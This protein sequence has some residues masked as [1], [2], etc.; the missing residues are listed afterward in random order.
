MSDGREWP[1][2]QRRDRGARGRHA[3]QR[4]VPAD[5]PR[6]DHWHQAEDPDPYNRAE[7]HYQ[8][9]PLPTGP[10]SGPFPAGPPSGPFPAPPS[11]RSPRHHPL[12]RHRVR[13]PRHH[14]LGRHRVRS[15]RHHPLGRQTA[16]RP[17][18]HSGPISRGHVA[19][20]CLAPPTAAHIRLRHPHGTAGPGAIHTRARPPTHTSARTRTGTATTSRGTRI[21]GL[22]RT[23]TTNLCRIP[24]AVVRIRI[25]TV[26][27][28]TAPDSLVHTGCGNLK[29]TFRTPMRR[30]DHGRRRRCLGRCLGSLP[31]PGTPGPLIRT[32]S[33]RAATGRRSRWTPATSR[34]VPCRRARP[35]SPALCP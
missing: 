23:R 3:R 16:I 11:V 17:D 18:R 19:P 29:V 25:R 10:G 33:P 8:R 32:G 27:E 24:I 6:P 26:L 35:R 9:G 31:E 20:P 12:G 21:P 1:R 14:P 5:S 34:W 4:G 7:R 30:T 2:D 28:T 13:S 22:P 15:P